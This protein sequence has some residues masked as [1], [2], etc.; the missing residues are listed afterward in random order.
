MEIYKNAMEKYHRLLPGA[1]DRN[2]NAWL[3]IKTELGKTAKK[4]GKVKHPHRSE[5]IARAVAVAHHL[6]ELIIEDQRL[7]D[8][9]R[10]WCLEELYNEHS[11]EQGGAI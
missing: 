6:V 7:D 10:R 11:R 4:F 3:K 8:A 2:R 9:G 1:N 5:T